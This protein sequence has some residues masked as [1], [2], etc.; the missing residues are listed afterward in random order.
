MIKWVGRLN[1]GAGKSQ[2]G[3]DESPGVA[4]NRLPVPAIPRIP[5][6]NLHSTTV[7]LYKVRAFNCLKKDFRK[8][9]EM[10]ITCLIDLNNVS[11]VEKRPVSSEYMLRDIFWFS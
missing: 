9:R 7:V 4:G 6:L 10:L 1:R 11:T 2:D 8:G 3:E 5:T